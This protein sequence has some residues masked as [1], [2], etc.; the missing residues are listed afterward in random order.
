[1]KLGREKKNKE[2]GRKKERPRWEQIQGIDKRGRGKK[3]RGEG[4][5]KTIRS[6]FLK[7]IMLG[8]PIGLPL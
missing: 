4:Q 5:G 7:K 3:R 2:K 6:R 8:A 1:M